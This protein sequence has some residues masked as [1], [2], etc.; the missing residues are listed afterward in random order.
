MLKPDLK[1]SLGSSETIGILIKDNKFLV[2]SQNKRYKEEVIQVIKVN[3]NLDPIILPHTGQFLMKFILLKKPMKE[4]L[5]NANFGLVNPT[6]PPS[7][8]NLPLSYYVKFIMDGAPAYL[9]QNLFIIYVNYNQLHMKPIIKGDDLIKKCFEK[10][11]LSLNVM[12]LSRFLTIIQSNSV[13]RSVTIEEMAELNF[14][15]I[16]TIAE[17]NNIKSITDNTRIIYR[18]LINYAKSQFNITY[19]ATDGSIKRLS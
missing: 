4:F 18:N 7:E 5:N 9:L 8:T 13:D 1:I 14:P 11:N 3:S 6:Q 19:Y 17:I 10:P 12:N 16:V 15:N 2:V